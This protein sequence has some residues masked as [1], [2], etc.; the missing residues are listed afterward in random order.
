MPNVSGSK[1][2]MCG[3]VTQTVSVLAYKPS[4]SMSSFSGNDQLIRLN[5][6]TNGM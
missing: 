1:L 2:V 4:F 5:F 6:S 3:T